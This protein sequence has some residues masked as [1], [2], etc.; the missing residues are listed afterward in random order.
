MN[1]KEWSSLFFCFTVIF[2]PSFAH[3]G[4]EDTARAGAKGISKAVQYTAEQIDLTL[5]GKRYT[6]HAND[7][8]ATVSQI[9]TWSEGGQLQNS[10]DVGLNLR[11][12][13]VEKHWQLRFSTYDEEEEE[14]NM[15]QR[16]VRTTARTKEYGTS[17]FF[18]QKLGDVRVGFQPKL[19]LKDP[20][21]MSYVLRFESAAEAKRFRIAPKLELFADGVKGTGQY[22]ALNFIFRPRQTIEWAIE[23]EEEYRT[24]GHSF[25]TRHGLSFDYIYNMWNRFGTAF[26]ATSE[27]HDFHLAALN[28][29]L[30]Y[31]HDIYKNLLSFTTSPFWGFAKAD[32][33][34]GRVGISF[35]LSATF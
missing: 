30:S 13:N 9:L 34:K 1:L 21:I 19:Q 29:S 31:T 11:L 35:N 12:P 4:L 5:A 27:N 3:A 16:H 6:D 26:V 8:R 18:L 14:R 22:F 23:N 28:Y 17:L 20:L 33:F 10:T 25:T 7:S 15:N 32:H 24:L 2:C